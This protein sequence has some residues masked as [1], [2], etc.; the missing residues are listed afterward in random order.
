MKYTASKEETLVVK[1]KPLATEGNTLPRI[2]QHRL[3]IDKSRSS[4]LS[5]TSLKVG[6]KRAWAQSP[7]TCIHYNK[8]EIY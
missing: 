8:F 2:K 5:G 7:I 1:K 6:S 3:S 4:K